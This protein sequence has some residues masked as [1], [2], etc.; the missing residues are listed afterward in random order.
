M[1]ALAFYG[2]TVTVGA[3]D[4]DLIPFDKNKLLL[5]GYRDKS[6]NTLILG[7]R[8]PGGANYPVI[9]LFVTAGGPD[10]DLLEFS[11][12]GANY[13]N[14]V[15]YL[16]IAGSNQLLYVRAKIPADADYGLHEG[17][18]INFKYLGGV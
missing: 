3:T 6:S 15:H 5:Q 18:Y 7:L 1:S 13:Y 16:Y 10:S 12:D 4:G 17:T 14:K 11:S 2:G 9:N 8:A